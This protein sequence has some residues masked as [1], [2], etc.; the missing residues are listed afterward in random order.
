[1]N[2]LAI[3]QTFETFF[4][5]MNRDSKDWVLIIPNILFSNNAKTTTGVPTV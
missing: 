3:K 2:L 1:M 5:V 4:V